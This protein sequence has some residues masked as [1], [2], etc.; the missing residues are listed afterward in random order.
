MRIWNVKVIHWSSLI[1][2]IIEKE[3]SLKH[4]N[5][6]RVSGAT[7]HALHGMEYFS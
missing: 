1:F 6:F 4:E 3:S 5:K 2:D 7:F